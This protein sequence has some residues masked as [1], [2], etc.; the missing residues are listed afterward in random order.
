MHTCAINLKN[1][2]RRYTPRHIPDDGI[3]DE[4]GGDVDETRQVAQILVKHGGH[5]A[6]T[7]KQVQTIREPDQA[8]V[9]RIRTNVIHICNKHARRSQRWS[10]T[11]A[12][13]DPQAEMWHTTLTT[14][15]RPKTCDIVVALTAHI[16]ILDIIIQYLVD[17]GRAIRYS[18]GSEGGRGRG[19]RNV[20]CNSVVR[21]V[22]GYGRT[23]R[24]K[25]TFCRV[26]YA[27]MQGKS[28]VHKHHG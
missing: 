4:L 10:G 7:R 11:E 15:A 28:P 14:C 13:L 19:G 6:H 21:S 22:D 17:Q 5:V 18:E 24:D 27:P 25:D 3:E 16:A 12:A 2:G 20:I 9:H 26:R 8:V 1:E 23:T